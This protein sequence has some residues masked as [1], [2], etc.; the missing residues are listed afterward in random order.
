MTAVGN[1]I[2]CRAGKHEK[3]AGAITA[4]RMEPDIRPQRDRGIHAVWKIL[5]EPRCDMVVDRMQER[6]KEWKGKLKL[7][8]RRVRRRRE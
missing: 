6:G 8:H 5:F 3:S 7:G 2:R 4:L 1:A